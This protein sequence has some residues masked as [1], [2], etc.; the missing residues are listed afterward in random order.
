VRLDAAE[1]DFPPYH[2]GEAEAGQDDGSL[3]QQP[4]APAAEPAPSP[5]Q[6]FKEAAAEKQA[7]EEPERDL[8]Q[9]G[10]CP[11]AM[12]GAW[13]LSGL[14][15]VVLLI[16]AIWISRRWFWWT[17]VVLVLLLWAY[18]F[19]KL[20]YRRLNVRYLLTTQRF[21]HE[22]GILRRVT[23]RIEVIDID[24]I[25]FEQSVLERLVGVGSIR[26]TSSDRTHPE[27]T[28]VGIEDVKTVSGII[29]DTRRSE[30]RRRGLHIESI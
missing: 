8:W 3:E 4:E 13:A 2:E 29:D 5:V 10:Y 6:K 18:Q 21:I 17:L 16:L 26:I 20:C 11:K 9:G 23:D 12:I 22:T 1:Q 15:T 19:L 24:D 14:V 28:L 27:L 7:E 30:R 25:T